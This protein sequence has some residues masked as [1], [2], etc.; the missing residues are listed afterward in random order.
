MRK[1]WI[2]FCLFG[3]IAISLN[4]QSNQTGTISGFVYDA[5]NGEALIGANVF[6]EN[7]LIGSGTNH[8]GY[9]VIPKVPAGDYTLVVHYIGYKPFNQQIDLQAGEEK[10]VIVKLIAEN[11]VMEKIV[12]TGDAQP[13]IERLF[14]KPISKIDL[15]AKQIN[16]IPQ[17][18]EADLLRALQTLPG[19]LPISD[20]SSALYVRGGTPDQNLYLIDGT[21][22]YNPEHAFGLF[23]TFNTDAIKKVE[24][25]K[26]GFGAQYGGRL[27]SILNVTNLDGNREEFEGSSAIS[28]LSAKTTLQMPIGQIGSISGS[29]RR[30]YFAQTIAKAID[31]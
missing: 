5:A 22:V 28:L 6:L 11:L 26:G 18:A 23:S 8:N 2:F 24:L 15:T 12:V 1:Y 13:Q 7:T 10:S 9:Y 3:L 29:F 19:I 27:S 14:E 31:D 25:S 17:V 4:A 16:Q 30:T 20:F 21:D